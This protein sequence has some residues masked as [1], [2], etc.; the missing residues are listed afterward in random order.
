VHLLEHVSLDVQLVETL[1]GLLST[2]LLN[3]SEE[4]VGLVQSVQETDG[5]VDG[6]GV[7]F[8]QVKQ[9][10][11]LLKVIQPGSETSG[12]HP[13]LL[14]PLLADLVEE[15]VFHK[16]FHS[17]SHGQLSLE[18][19]L[20]VLKVD[21]DLVDESVNQLALLQV[22]VL[23]RATGVVSQFGVDLVD[24]ESLG[25]DLDFVEDSLGEFSGDIN[26]SGSTI[27]STTTLGLKLNQDGEQVVTLGSSEIDFSVG[28]HS[29]G[30]RGLSGKLVLNVLDVLIVSS[31][32]GALERSSSFSVGEKFSF[33]KEL[34]VEEMIQV[35]FTQESIPVINDMTTIH[36]FSDKISEIIPWHFT[37]TTSTF[38]VVLEHD[39][40]IAEITFREGV[41]HVESLGSEL[42]ALTHDGVEIAETK[43]DG[44]DLGLTL[45][46][47]LLLVHGDSTLHVGFESCGRLVGELDGS[48]KQVDGNTVTGV[49]RQ[50][51]S[52]VLV[53]SFNG[54]GVELLG[55]LVQESRH[56][57][58]VL[59]HDPLSFFVSHL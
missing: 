40:G 13:G 41:S 2:N 50:E 6:G 31:S 24:G 54:K 27:S 1:T 47:F 56:E 28:M 19:Q 17:G 26:D 35:R 16:V 9:L 32:N 34:L 20:K 22:H 58:H 39:R 11:S 48:L 4:R 57:M 44:S 8:P 23:V 33:I 46:E 18:S 55:D 38:H 21:D 49:R 15:D 45:I 30:E 12:G 43:E 7:I 36:D 53:R 3:G 52:E 42:S 25:L 10:K 51:E 37:A 14:G 29:E 5:L 59:Q